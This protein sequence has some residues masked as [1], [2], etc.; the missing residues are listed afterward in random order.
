MVQ[1]CT[2]NR[3]TLRRHLPEP[4]VHQLLASRV[5]Q[6]Y[7]PRAPRLQA[8]FP[9]CPR[10]GCIVWLESVARMDSRVEP[11]LDDRRFVLIHQLD[12]VKDWQRGAASG[13]SYWDVADAF[14]RARQAGRVGRIMSSISDQDVSWF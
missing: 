11:F 2:E 9:A 14:V 7:P 4:V 10:L 3:P 12:F 13:V 6:Y 8:V 5:S 1:E